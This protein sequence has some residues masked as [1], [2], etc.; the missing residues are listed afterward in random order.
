MVAGHREGVRMTGAPL[1]CP[2]LWSH[3]YEGQGL[4]P[5]RPWVPGTVLASA[6]CRVQNSLCPGRTP[7]A[8]GR[9]GA[10]HINKLLWLF[11][12][13]GGA[14]GWLCQVP[15]R[16]RCLHGT[17]SCQFLSAQEGW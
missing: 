16:R 12:L 14:E 1:P 3:L 2:C 8:W 11:S 7:P 4:V 5:K 13:S 9:N 10:G 6:G 17:G 15:S